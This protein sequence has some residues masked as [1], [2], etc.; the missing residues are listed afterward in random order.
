M[1]S[2]LLASVFICLSCLACDNER[3]DKQK[4]ET[5]AALTDATASYALSS[6]R[7]YNDLVESLYNELTDKSPGLKKLETELDLLAK[8][9]GDSTELVDKYD[10]K[11]KSYYS[12]ARNHV[13]QVKDSVLRNKI[14]IW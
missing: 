12:S 7:G 4:N 6:S 3:I 1:K 11:N 14:R 2:S 9:K 5:P 10:E 8:T 13:E